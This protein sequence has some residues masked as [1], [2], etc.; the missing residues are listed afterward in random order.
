MRPWLPRTIPRSWWYLFQHWSGVAYEATRTAAA[1]STLQCEKGKNEM[2][3]L[4]PVTSEELRS[5]TAK[6]QVVHQW[7]VVEMAAIQ[8]GPNTASGSCQDH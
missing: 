6:L 1:I 8:V 4:S 5:F 2:Q 3:H 7:E